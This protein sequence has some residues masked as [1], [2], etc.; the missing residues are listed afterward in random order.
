MPVRALVR[1]VQASSVVSI[2]QLLVAVGTGS[3]Q[4][5]MRNRQIWIGKLLRALSHTASSEC[6]L[7]D[8]K[9]SLGSRSSS[10]GHILPR[11]SAILASLLIPVSA[12]F[13][14]RGGQ[15][16][17]INR[18]VRPILSDNCLACH[19]ADAGSRKA[20]LRLDTKE[21]MFETNQARPAVVPGIPRKA[22]SGNAS[23]RATRRM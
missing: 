23:A 14:Q 7:N 17:P 19:G 20:G 2:P 4:T 13:P 22:S 9:K 18:D 21:G 15:R 11:P 3:W 10:G 12:A 6:R 1:R 5:L 16:R 8:M